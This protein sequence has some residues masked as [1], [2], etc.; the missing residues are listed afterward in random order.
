MRDARSLLV[1]ER[2]G[3]VIVFALFA[4]F[5][6]YEAWRIGLRLAGAGFLHSDFFAQWSFARFAWTQDP[7]GIY[8]QAALRAFQTTLWPGL[9]QDFPYPYPPVF[10]LWLWPLGALPIGP[11]YVAWMGVTLALYFAALLRPGLGAV[12]SGMVLLAPAVMVNASYGQNG[13]LTAALLVGGLRLLPRHPAAA[14]VAFGLLLF[15]PQFALFVP[16]ALFA[17][18]QWRPIAAA[19]A[20]VSVQVV[21]CGLLFGWTPW[22]DWAGGLA[23]HGAWV[24][25]TVNYFLKV[26]PREALLAAGVD[27]GLVRWVHAGLALAA[28]AAV[29]TAWRRRAAG[30]DGVLIAATFAAAPYAF[31]YDLPALT[32][33]TVAA[34]A[35][36]PRGA[37][38]LLDDA[39]IAAAMTVPAIHLLT[40]RFYWAGGVVL[41]VFLL[42]VTLRARPAAPAR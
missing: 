6:G 41:P 36:R 25:A 7:A 17:A 11:A 37:W 8:D 35:L 13:F 20:T 31:L 10:L 5:A 15:K 1:L 28:A 32:A 38:R 34:W 29:W 19:A 23:A 4:G 14:G 16:L 27:P 18:G 40:S 39:V 3:L 9:R 26:T 42:L 12:E 21:L 22:L 24:D 33:A 2:L 30:A